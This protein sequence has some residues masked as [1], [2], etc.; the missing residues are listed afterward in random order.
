MRDFNASTL[1]ALA[2]KGITILRPVA[3]PTGRFADY[4]RAYSVND[5]GCGRIWT[6]EQVK[7]AVR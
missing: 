4:D 6:F 5:N 7:E 2:R 1:R 3:V